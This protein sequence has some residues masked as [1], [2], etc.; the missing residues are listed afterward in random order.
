MYENNYQFH[1]I[2]NDIYIMNIKVLNYLNIFV[3]DF[4]FNNK[5]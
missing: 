5:Y 3:T 1:Y 2:N 4:F